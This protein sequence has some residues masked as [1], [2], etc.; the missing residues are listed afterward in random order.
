MNKFDIP[1]YNIQKLEK[2]MPNGKTNPLLL[3]TDRGFFVV[4]SISNVDG[5]K[6]LINEFVCYKLAKLLDIPIPDAALINIDQNSINA[7]PLLQK[8]NITPGLH[9]GSEFIRK[10]Q[11]SVQPPLINIIQNQEDI[12]SIILFDQIIYNNDRTENLGN[13][14]IDLKEKRVLVIDHSHPFKIGVLWDKIELRKIQ[15]EPICLIRDFHGQN[16]K[17]LLKYVN[18][19]SPFNK[20]QSK[21]S[22][23]TQ[24]DVD[25]CFEQIPEEW[26]L[27]PEDETALNQFIWHRLNSVNEFLVLLKDQCPNWKGGDLIG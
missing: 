2:E 4:K 15:E 8:H 12:P 10:S 1:T 6:V 14:L 27:N 13:L 5:P 20:I 22:S 16:Y 9:F 26:G 3:Q 19:N 17:V 18:G 11:P 21:I 25:W 24:E 7:D 23:I